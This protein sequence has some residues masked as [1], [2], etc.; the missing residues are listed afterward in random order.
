MKKVISFE[1]FLIGMSLNLGGGYLNTASAD[2]GGF[3]YDAMVDL[4]LYF[5]NWGDVDTYGLNLEIGLGGTT[6]GGGN[7]LGSFIAGV[8]HFGYPNCHGEPCSGYR[9]GAGYKMAFDKQIEGNAVYG[10][11]LYSLSWL[12]G[13]HRH[14]PHTW[15]GIGPS[16]EYYPDS[17][18]WGIGGKVKIGF[19]S[20]EWF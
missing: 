3:S 20:R 10:E 15:L 5:D 12:D 19:D 9:I 13:W 17:G 4:G 16:V 1:Y 11:L 18:D 14:M 8:T 7:T 6:Y 2:L